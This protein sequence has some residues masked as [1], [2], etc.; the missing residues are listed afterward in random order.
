MQV[1]SPTRM[2]LPDPTNTNGVFFA[3]PHCPGLRDPKPLLREIQSSDARKAY[4]RFPT[5]RHGCY[6]PYAAIALIAHQAIS[7]AYTGRCLN[8]LL[9]NRPLLNRQG[10]AWR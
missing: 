7:F 5:A 9:A 2:D 8:R 4:Y 1:R 10:G 6:A 3:M